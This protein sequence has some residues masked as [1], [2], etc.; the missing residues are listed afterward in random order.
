MTIAVDRVLCYMRP[1]WLLCNARWVPHRFSQPRVARGVD[2][3]ELDVCSVRTSGPCGYLCD[4]AIAI[5]TL[6]SLHLIRSR[7]RVLPIHRTVSNRPLLVHHPTPSVR[8]YC[9]LATLQ[10]IIR[11]HHGL[12]TMFPIFNRP[13]F[14]RA[15]HF[16]LLFQLYSLPCCSLSDTIDAHRAHLPA[17]FFHP[18]PPVSLVHPSAPAPLSLSLLLP[19]SF[20]YALHR[21][22]PMHRTI[23][24]TELTS[25]LSSTSST[26]VVQHATAIAIIAAAVAALAAAS[27]MYS[28]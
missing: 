2:S 6:P 27:C 11:V 15:S 16:V 12:R 8:P 18:Q 1:M 3:P 22:C 7:F 20:P 21:T 4:L 26:A 25:C 28:V 19:F 5:A 9:I 17:A 24:P 23:S 14:H 13:R 10:C